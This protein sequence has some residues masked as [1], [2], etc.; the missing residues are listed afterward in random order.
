MTE[1]ICKDAMYKCR[2]ADLVQTAYKH[3]IGYELGILACGIMEKY[4]HMIRMYRYFSNPKKFKDHTNSITQMMNSYAILQSDYRELIAEIVLYYE[5]LEEHR[6]KQQMQIKKARIYAKKHKMTVQAVLDLMNKG[7]DIENLGSPNR[8]SMQTD[9]PLDDEYLDEKE[10]QEEIEKAMNDSKLGAN[11]FKIDPKTF[12]LNETGIKMLQ[13]ETRRYAKNLF[14]K[15]NVS[16]EEAE[17]KKKL[18]Y[19]MWAEK[20]DGYDPAKEGVHIDDTIARLGLNES[21][22]LLNELRGD[23]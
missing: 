23:V 19:I 16:S 2:Q 17:Y 15:Q 11:T 22:F 5:V 7:I 3:T 10:L 1:N 13:S 4:R 8:R 9:P 20:W 12:G 6:R 14:A 21:D 18:R